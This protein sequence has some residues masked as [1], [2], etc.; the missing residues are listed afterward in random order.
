MSDS[1]RVKL[2]IETVD[3]TD[4]M[5]KADVKNP[6]QISFNKGMLDA[7]EGEISD[8]TLFSS[9]SNMLGMFRMV[10]LRKYHA[11]NDN[12]NIDKVLTSAESIINNKGLPNSDKNKLLQEVADLKNEYQDTLMGLNP[13]NSEMNGGKPLMQTAGGTI[14]AT[15]QKVSDVLYARLLHGDFGK[16]QTLKQ[17]GD[18]LPVAT[19]FGS[20]ELWVKCVSDVYAFLKTM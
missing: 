4:I 18:L 15:Q 13:Q 19:I 1:D 16:N 9:I 6:F 8:S 17:Q 10:V 2:F 14:L 3:D 7:I 5:G 11:A 12:V 20:N